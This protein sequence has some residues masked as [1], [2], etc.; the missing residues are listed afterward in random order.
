MQRKVLLIIVICILVTIGIIAY[1]PLFKRAREI[2]NMEDQ[3]GYLI[4]KVEAYKKKYHKLPQYMD[5]MN[6][7]LPDNYPFSYAITKD[8]SNYLVGFEIAPFKSMVYYSDS[9]KWAPQQ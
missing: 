2:N 1:L 5:D 3:A 7:D 6:L 4:K 9:K 8:S